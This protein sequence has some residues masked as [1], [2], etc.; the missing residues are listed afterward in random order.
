MKVLDLKKRAFALEYLMNGQNAKQAALSVGYKESTAAQMGFLLKNDPVVKETFKELGEIFSLSSLNDVNKDE[1]GKDIADI[2]EVL[3]TATR[4]IR[5]EETEDVVMKPKSKVNPDGTVA[6]SEYDILAARPRI[7]DVNDAMKI[8][9]SYYSAV[10]DSGDEK[11]CGVVIM[12]D[13]NISIER[14]E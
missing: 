3:Q 12:P 4:I 6:D 2:N 7:K 8:L 1:I 9:M 14:N 10:T 11:E 5:R 13:I